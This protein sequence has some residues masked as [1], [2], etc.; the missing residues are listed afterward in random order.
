MASVL[1]IPF[2]DRIDRGRRSAPIGTAARLSHTTCRT[3]PH[4]DGS[5][6]LP[7]LADNSMSAAGCPLPFR[8]PLRFAAWC[9]RHAVQSSAARCPLQHCAVN[10]VRWTPSAASGSLDAGRCTVSGSPCIAVRP[11][12][13]CI[14]V[15]IAACVCVCVCVCE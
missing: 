5:Q 13:V 3:G 8:C 10:V 6:C 15:Y 12:Y 1:P 9:M 14:H 11:M 2:S 4:Q 7:C